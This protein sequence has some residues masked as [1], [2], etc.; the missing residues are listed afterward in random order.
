MTPQV[1]GTVGE[2]AAAGRCL[3]GALLWMAAANSYPDYDGTTV[4]LAPAAP[5]AASDAAVLDT[6]RRHAADMAGLPSACAVHGDHLSFATCSNSRL[7][8]QEQQPV[9][10]WTS[11]MIRARVP[12]SLTLLRGAGRQPASVQICC[13]CCP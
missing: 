9:Q 1:L 13:H 10:G 6:L 8:P 2:H 7:S 11:H 12:R 4:Y 3:G 5:P